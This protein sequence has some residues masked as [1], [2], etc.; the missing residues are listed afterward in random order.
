MPVLGSN[1]IQTLDVRPVVPSPIPFL[2]GSTH[3]QTLEVLPYE[4]RPSASISE[5]VLCPVT[6]ADNTGAF[7]SAI[8]RTLK[9]CNSTEAVDDYVEIPAS[10]RIASLESVMEY[11]F[12][13]PSFVPYISDQP[14]EVIVPDIVLPDPVAHPSSFDNPE[15]DLELDEAY[16]DSVVNL[17]EAPW[18]FPPDDFEEFAEPDLAPANCKRCVGAL[19]TSLHTF[20][21]CPANA[22]ILS[23]EVSSTQ[24]LIKQAQEGFLLQPC[25]WVRGILPKSNTAVSSIYD[26]SE[27]VI[28][29]YVGN[30]TLLPLRSWPAG[31]YYT[32]AAGGPYGK[33][34]TLRRIAFGV[35]V[36]LYNDGPCLAWGMH[37][38]LPGKIQSVPRGELF[39]I[40]Y[41]VLGVV[42]GAVTVV[43]DSLINFNL[44][45][46]SQLAA[47][48]STNGDLFALLFRHLSK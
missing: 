4:V 14:M 39:A 40:V 15:L 43:T 24:R 17:N 46:G 6:D 20:W 36:M 34:A 44:W 35:A 41:V 27:T 13:G 10:S 1:I 2:P 3:R 29:V 19:E 42:S 30:S 16:H 31:T 22:D 9:V 37:S 8:R 25:L 23:K 12:P 48:S 26:P 5:P 18:E 47:M 11:D 38:H 21:T 33:F 32:D 28:P 7:P 45:K